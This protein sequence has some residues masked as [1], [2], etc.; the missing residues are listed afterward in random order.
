MIPKIRA[1][2]FSARFETVGIHF[3][4]VMVAP[5]SKRADICFIL[6]TIA[7]PYQ[8]NDILKNI[9]ANTLIVQAY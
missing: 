4:D 1:I 3:N 5:F 6:K 7:L 2:E 9:N 8:I